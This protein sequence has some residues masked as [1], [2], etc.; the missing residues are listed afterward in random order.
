MTKKNPKTKN[1]RERF[2]KRQTDRQG[3]RSS[4]NILRCYF[5][6]ID[7][8][9]RA[10]DAAQFPPT[11]LSWRPLLATGATVK[12]HRAGG[13]A[14]AKHRLA[15]C[16]E[17]RSHRLEAHSRPSCALSC[18]SV[19]FGAPSCCHGN[20]AIHYWCFLGS[21]PHQ[22]ESRIK[23]NLSASCVWWTGGFGIECPVCSICLNLWFFILGKYWCT[24]HEYIQMFLQ[25]K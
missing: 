25:S 12:D 2:L 15:I 16:L 11:R 17:N 24:S 19:Q 10:D 1:K 8:A 5:F 13:N 9:L 3:F 7:S 6:F 18:L 23:T 20:S 14:N 4:Q 22:K 21:V